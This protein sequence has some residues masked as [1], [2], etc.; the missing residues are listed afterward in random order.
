VYVSRETPA[1]T[2]LRLRRVLAAA[3][4]DVLK[5]F[6][7]YEEFPLEQFPA[8]VRPDAIALVRDADRWSQLV[9]QQDADRPQERFRVWRCTFPNGLDNS[10][11]VGWLA[12]HIK[13]KTGSGVFVVCGHNS[14]RGGIYDYW[15]CPAEVSEAVVAEVQALASG[16]D[17]D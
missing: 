4:I 11:F 16:S 8:R 10:G 17:S 5:G 3:V 15:G 12:T 9:P 2:D 6:W 1:Q 14:A 7:W 13:G